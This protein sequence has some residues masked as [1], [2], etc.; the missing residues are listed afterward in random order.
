MSVLE[1][2]LCALVGSGVYSLAVYPALMVVLSRLSRRRFDRRPVRPGVS[3]I[4]AAFNEEAS[5]AAKLEN[6]LALDYP[7]DRLEII[8][9]SDGSTDGT[10][11]IVRGYADRGVRLLRFE[12]GMG[13]SAML[14]RAAEAASGEILAFSDATGL[15]SR[16]AIGDMASHF[17]DSRVGCVSGRVGYRYDES[18]TARGFGAYQRYVRTL[19]RA[20]A[21]FGAGFNAAGSIHS[22]RKSVFRAGPPDTFMDMV[23]PLHT[24][25]Q[26]LATTLEE[27]AVSMEESR[28]RTADEFRARLRIALR[29][30]RFLAYALPRLPILRSPMYCFQVVSHKFLRWM[31]GPSLPV[32]VVL[33]ILLLGARPLYRWLL[34]A[35]VAYYAL[36]ALGLL[37]GRA[38]PGLPGLS[39]LVFFNATNLAY[40]TSLVRYLR[41][42]RMRRWVPSR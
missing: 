37:L 12:G 42:D 32:I 3:L 29:S 40:L 33:N 21:A 11:A 4:I 9:A 2:F 10:D 6:S 16:N 13:K 8:V 27:E 36:T 39:T 20:E 15:W 38:L 22:I 34:L 5:I 30:W 25:M 26:G 31:I 19:R 35:Q 1:A 17:A 28:T 7:A 41:G 18:T 24:A 23:D 14:N